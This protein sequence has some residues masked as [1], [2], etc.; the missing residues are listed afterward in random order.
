[1][2]VD[3]AGDKLSYVDI[4][5]REETRVEV[6]VACLP[7]TDYVYVLC[8]RSQSSEDFLYAIASCFRAIGGATKIIVPD[9]L[10]AAVKKTDPYEPE[11]ARVME[12]FA[13]HYGCVVIPARPRHPK[14][15][16]SVERCVAM[17]YRHIYAP[18]RNRVFYSLEELNAAVTALALGKYQYSFIRGLVCRMTAG[19]PAASDEVT[20]PPANHANIRGKGQFC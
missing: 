8:V 2:L 11:I 7:A 14:D 4:D 6:F 5:T 9:N 1:M 3:F 19:I 18:L 15:K 20:P 13:N 12:D 10:K 17:S 16:A